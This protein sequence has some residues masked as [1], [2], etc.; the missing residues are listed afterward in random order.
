MFFNNKLLFHITIGTEAF[1]MGVSSQ[2][3]KSKPVTGVYLRY[4]SSIRYKD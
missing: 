4:V 1:P 3:G 2:A